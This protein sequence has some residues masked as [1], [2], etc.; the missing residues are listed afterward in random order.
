LHRPQGIWAL[1]PEGMDDNM[2]V[3]LWDGT[4]DDWGDGF[5]FAESLDAPPAAE[6]AAA[7]PQFPPQHRPSQAGA[8]AGQERA[9]GAA[10]RGNLR[11]HVKYAMKAFQGMIA[12][13]AQA[14]EQPAQDGFD[15]LDGPSSSYVLGPQELV[16]R[17]VPLAQVAR[18]MAA[19]RGAGPLG[20]NAGGDIDDMLNSRENDGESV[21]SPIAAL[22]TEW[23]IPDLNLIFRPPK[24]LMEAMAIGISPGK[25]VKLAPNAKVGRSKWK[26]LKTVMSSGLAFKQGAEAADLYSEE[27]RDARKKQL[28]LEVEQLK[29]FLLSITKAWEDLLAE[30]DD[31]YGSIRSRTSSP[32]LLAH[33]A[34]APETS[35]IVVADAISVLQHPDGRIPQ[36]S[37]VAVKGI[38]TG[39]CQLCQGLPAQTTVRAGGLLDID[40]LAGAIAC[41]YP[42]HSS[43]VQITEVCGRAPPKSAAAK[44]KETGKTSNRLN[45]VCAFKMKV[46]GGGDNVTLRIW[47]NGKTQTSGCKDRAML[48]AVNRCICEAITNI[49]AQNMQHNMPS[50]IRGDIEFQHRALAQLGDIRVLSAHILGSWN[51][52]LRSVGAKLDMG[53]LCDF[54]AGERFGD[55]VFKVSHVKPK[56][57]SARFNNLSLYI[58]REC[59]TRWKDDGSDQTTVYVNVYEA[60]KCSV[61]AAPDAEV[62]EELADIVCDMLMEAFQQ[63]HIRVDIDYAAGPPSKKART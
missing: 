45:N 22:D 16:A 26:T 40:S 20:G 2:G 17:A 49:S 3:P 35:K 8:A 43:D 50:V 6:H 58:R 41:P 30:M 14:D 24:F 37:A 11:A 32:P 21:L 27:E 46:Q 33:E 61:L 53:N 57:N 15:G 51:L 62:A 13:S 60:G 36:R 48:L 42:S 4:P 44:D 56:G 63:D 23:N 7:P 19:G 59:L 18:P 12:A 9:Q 54:L 47:A 31:G 52:D 28:Q 55:R 34:V 38:A 5:D 29:N 39:I 1:L 10:A 25:W